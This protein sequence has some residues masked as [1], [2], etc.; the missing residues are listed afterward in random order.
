MSLE[1]IIEAETKVKSKQGFIKQ[2]V[3]LYS[4]SFAERFPNNSLISLF[5]Q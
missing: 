3:P 4:I 2:V 5:V 1:D